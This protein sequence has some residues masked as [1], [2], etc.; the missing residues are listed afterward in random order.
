MATVSD[1]KFFGE[2]EGRCPECGRDPVKLGRVNLAGFGHRRCCIDCCFGPPREF[3]V[4]CPE[5]GWWQ[6]EGEACDKCGEPMRADGAS[7]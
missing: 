6:P 7:Y 1:V 4:N 5:C 3:W 2:S